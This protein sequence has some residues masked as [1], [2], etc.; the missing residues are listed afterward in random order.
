[1]P[2]FIVVFVNSHLSAISSKY[3]HQH[4]SHLLTTSTPI[5]LRAAF[6]LDSPSITILGASLPVH[7]FSSRSIYCF[8][9]SL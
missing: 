3:R 6:S 1:M 7:L 9:H 5:R 2:V 8:S 4:H